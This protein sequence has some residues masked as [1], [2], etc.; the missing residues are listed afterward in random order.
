MSPEL[1]TCLRWWA[2]LLYLDKTGQW[3]VFQKQ[4]SHWNKSQL[5]NEWTLTQYTIESHS[6]LCVW[7]HLSF[8]AVIKVTSWFGAWK[9]RLGK[10]KEEPTS[11]QWQNYRTSDSEKYCQS[12]SKLS[13]K[14]AEMKKKINL[15]E[16]TV[17]FYDTSISMPVLVFIFNFRMLCHC[18][19]S[20]LNQLAAA[21]EHKVMRAV[22]VNKNGKAVDNSL[23]FTT[24]FHKAKETCKFRW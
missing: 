3:E 24:K 10:Q 16:C 23:K 22:T 6:M 8:L 13:P 7:N 11:K 9:L 14:K 19:G 12:K 20:I 1:T 18:S 2:V 21:A 17:T 5:A 15:I 4:I